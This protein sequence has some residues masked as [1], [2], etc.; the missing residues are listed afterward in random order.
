MGTRRKGETDSHMETRTYEE[1]LARTGAIAFPVRGVSMRPLIMEGRDVALVSAKQGRLGRFDVGLFKRGANEYV[2][3]RVLFVTED[4][5][6]FCGDSQD[7]TEMVDEGQV[8]G[9]LTGLVRKGR[10][11]DLA[12]WAYRCYVMLWCRPF[13]LRRM[14]LRVLHRMGIWVPGK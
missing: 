2:L 5:Y 11:L 13:G 4:G 10:W 14:L 8:L 6:L 9:V 12:G 7:F 1:E 3:H